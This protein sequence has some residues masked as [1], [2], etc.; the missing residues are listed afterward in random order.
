MK[1]TALQYGTTRITEKMAFPCG[2]AE[3]EIPIALLFF[4]IETEDR[5]ILVDTGCD[6]MPGFPLY[7]HEKPVQTLARLGLSPSD[8]TDVILTHAHQDHADCARHYSGSTFWLHRDAYPSARKFLPPQA[9]V[10]LFDSSSQ[11]APGITVQYVGGHAKGSSIVLLEEAT[12]LCGDECYTRQNLADQIPTGA[13][14][15]PEKSLAFI[16]QYS[17]P[18][19]RAIV[20]HDPDLVGGIGTLQL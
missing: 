8:I 16:R 7:T 1:L 13:S 5:R 4:L 14:R 10:Q 12:V 17:A 11:P 2:D 6:T 18:A 19:Y 15:C 9:A 3:K 20:F